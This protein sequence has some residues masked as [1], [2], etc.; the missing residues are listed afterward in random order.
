MFGHGADGHERVRALD[1]AAV[2]QLDEHA[3][4]GA[5]DGG[6]PAAFGDLAAARL[7]HLLDHGGGVGVLARQHLVA[8]G[9]QRDGH[10]GLEVAGGE[11][12]AGDARAD[13]HEV[14]GHLVELVDVAP[15]EDPLAVRL[16]ARQHA[17]VGAGGD[18][19]DVALQLVGHRALGVDDLHPVRGQPADLVGEP[20][21]TG[22]DPHALADQPL[23]DVGRLR[24]RQALDAVVDRGQVE[25]DR[26]QVG[27]L[28]PEDGGVAHRRHGAGGGDERLGGDAV[29]E[30][31]GAADAVPLDDGDL[32][33]Q[34]G[35][36]QRGFVAGRS[37]ADDHDAGHGSF[38]ARGRVV[39]PVP[40]S[41]RVPFSHPARAPM[42]LYAAYGSNMDPEQ[43]LR[44]CPSSPHTGT[45]WIR[46]LAAHLRRRGV[47]LGGRDGDPRPRRPRR[48]RRR[49]RSPGVF[50]A[51]YDL[52]E[53]DERALDAWEGADSGLYRGCTC[54]CTP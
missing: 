9:D 10:A 35:G 38:F 23:V 17:R 14:L 42:G 6:G 25:P 16:G 2:G 24:H 13:D 54:G 37:A 33:T 1:R 19:D 49:G 5:A 53:A 28:Q 52:T 36:D 3:L 39:C 34:L 26:G 45:G 27:A 4:L 32:R 22:D 41:G 29:G 40:S 43:M 51:L 15:V 31:A 8:G 7:E 20:A 12:G 21:L 47:R 30:D 50:V 46:G 44:R 18:E 48:G 11:L